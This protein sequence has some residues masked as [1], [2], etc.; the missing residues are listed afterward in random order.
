MVQYD[1]GKSEQ[2]IDPN[3]TLGTPYHVRIVAADSKVDVLYNGEQ[4]R[5]AAHGLGLVLQGRG[6]R[7]VQ[8]EQGR[9]ADAAG[10]SRCTRSASAMRVDALSL[11]WST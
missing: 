4:G 6:L 9:C 1:D 2:V 5:G 8:R 7:A 10:R 3:Y 11:Q